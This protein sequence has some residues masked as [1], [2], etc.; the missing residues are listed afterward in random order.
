MQEDLSDR[1]YGTPTTEGDY[2]VTFTVQDSAF[3]DE[4]DAQQPNTDTK[5]VPIKIKSLTLDGPKR[6]GVVRTNSVAKEQTYTVTVSNAADAA[7]VKLKKTQKS[8]GDVHDIPAP[9]IDGT[10][11]TFKVKGKTASD[12]NMQDDVTL[13]ATSDA[14]PTGDSI[15]ISVVIPAKVDSPHHQGIFNN[16]RW[17]P[18][19]LDRDSHPPAPNCP[20]GSVYPANG[21]FV[22]LTIEV[23]DQYGNGIG[24]LYEG[25]EI[26]ENDG[27]KI[28]RKL[29]RESKYIDTTGGYLPVTDGEGKAVTFPKA[30]GANWLKQPSRNVQNSDL[31]DCS[32][33]VEVDGFKLNPGVVNRKYRTIY[34]DKLEI[35]W[36]D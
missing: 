14:N 12:P 32:R 21:A 11:V 35:I 9:T 5:T 33:D 16:V 20:I 7:S 1:F 19:V 18:H 34:P 36:P 23:V 8:T 10:K 13:T 3:S 29:D 31:K 28:N 25:A 24:D 4:A 2:S 17:S 15:D 26:T 22:D 27:I 30:V 6:I